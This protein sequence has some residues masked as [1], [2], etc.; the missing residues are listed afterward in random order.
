MEEQFI[1][2]VQHEG[3]DAIV[4]VAGDVDS[5]SCPRLA[6]VIRQAMQAEKRRVIVDIA[7]V[8][9]VDSAG[10]RVFVAARKEADAQGRI[11]I[12]AGANRGAQRLLEITGLSSMFAAS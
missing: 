1:A 11:F 7:N 3:N 9:F 10:L 2:V 12:L 4:R 8:T 6:D 5:Y